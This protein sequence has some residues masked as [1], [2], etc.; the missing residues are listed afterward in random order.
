MARTPLS[1]PTDA[2]LAILR[3]LWERGPS[4]VRDVH[5]V[6]TE[7][8]D[9]AYT[10]TGKVLQVMTEKGLATR[11][12]WGRVHRYSAA[13]PEEETQRQLVDDLVERAFGG[14]AVKMM[15]R[16]LSSDKA[17][18]ADLAEMRRLLSA[19]KDGNK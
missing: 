1:R 4:T 18:P 19:K 10:T 14:S 15:V 6:I 2:E 3:I 17:S 16:A 12:E 9:A 7:G 8:R 11:E 5:D 13:A